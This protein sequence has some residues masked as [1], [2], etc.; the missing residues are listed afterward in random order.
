MELQKISAEIYCKVICR[1]ILGYALICW[2]YGWFSLAEKL[3]QMFLK[4][5]LD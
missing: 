4:K 3:I 1:G 2:I 5:N